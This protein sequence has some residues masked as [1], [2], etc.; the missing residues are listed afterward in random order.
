VTVTVEVVEPSAGID[1]G[2]T[3]I[4]DVDAAGTATTFNESEGPQLADEPVTHGLGSMLVE[5]AERI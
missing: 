2:D 5:V 4:V 1:D 3:P